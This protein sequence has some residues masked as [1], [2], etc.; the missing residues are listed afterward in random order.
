MQETRR[1]EIRLTRISAFSEASLQRKAWKRS[2][3][4]AED[5]IEQLR[6]AGTGD[7]REDRR[8]DDARDERRRE[9]LCHQDEDALGIRIP[10][11]GS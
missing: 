5:V 8:P 2:R 4:T 3:E 9:R 1:T 6:G 7:G 10:Q 11:A